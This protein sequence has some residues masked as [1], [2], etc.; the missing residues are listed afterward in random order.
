MNVAPVGMNSNGMEAYAS[1]WLFLSI[2]YAFNVEDI[3]SLYTGSTYVY[4]LQHVFGVL[5]EQSLNRYYLT[6]LD[7]WLALGKRSGCLPLPSSIF[8]AISCCGYSA[9]TFTWKIIPI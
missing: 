9:N 5:N 8:T 2:S 1:A 4:W 7:S 6:V 3:N